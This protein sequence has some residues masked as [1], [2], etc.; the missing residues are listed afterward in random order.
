MENVFQLAHNN[1]CLSMQLDSVIFLCDTA[2]S[3]LSFRTN[4]RF[5][6]KR[7]TPDASLFAKLDWIIDFDKFFL[8]YV[9]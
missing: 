1:C 3:R 8:S 7:A 2:F 6:G 9:Y 5:E 4:F